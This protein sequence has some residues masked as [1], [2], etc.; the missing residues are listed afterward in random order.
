MLLEMQEYIP[1]AAK[2][3][4]NDDNGEDN[5]DTIWDDSSTKQQSGVEGTHLCKNFKTNLKIGTCFWPITW[6]PSIVSYKFCPGDSCAAGAAG[7]RVGELLSRKAAC[8]TL[9]F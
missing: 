6:C 7:M 3:T 5:H 9:T 4:Y 1:P 8:F 2:A